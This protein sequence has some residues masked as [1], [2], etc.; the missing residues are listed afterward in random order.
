MN[1]PEYQQLFEKVNSGDP[2]LGQYFIDLE[3]AVNDLIDA[4]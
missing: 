2:V 4:L 3:T 1:K